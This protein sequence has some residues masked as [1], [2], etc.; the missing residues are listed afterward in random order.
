M[1]KKELKPIFYMF[2]IIVI[3]VAFVV[4]WANTTAPITTLQTQTNES[5]NIAGA[6]LSSNNINSSYQFTLTYAQANT[7]HTPISN[8][9]L[10]NGT[11]SLI[12]STNYTFNSTTGVLK[13]TNGTYWVTGGGRNNIT[14]TVYNY[15][16]PSYLE[17]SSS[18][19]VITLIIFFGA[20]GILL[21]VIAYMNW[22]YIKSV[23][24]S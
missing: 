15:K 3:G 17:D 13:L 14:L 7:G 24:R 22:D 21:G 1:M 2:M 5:I 4:S 18:R 12:T 19:S 8:F 23:F 9:A 11:G 20:L 16:D 6:R 10:Y